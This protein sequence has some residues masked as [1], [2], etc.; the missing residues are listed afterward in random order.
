MCK[1]SKQEFN[2]QRINTIPKTW[3]SKTYQEFLEN[4]KTLGDSKYK[5]FQSKLI[6]THYEIIGLRIP[7]LRKIAKQISKTDIISFLNVSNNYYYEEIM[8]NGF[9]VSYIN[10]EPTFDEYF[11]KHIKYIDDWSLCDSFCNSLKQVTKNKDKYFNLAKELSLKEDEF[12]SR[13]GLIIILSHFIDEVYLK[14]IFSLLNTIKSEKYYINMAEA[15]L[16]CEI[17]TKFPQETTKYLIKNK[18]NKFTQNKSISK[19]RDSYRVSKEEKD[20]LNTLKRK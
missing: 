6:Y 11:L 2:Q 14:E 15:W 20:Y 5:D 12:I 13:V 1:V 8:L 19:I 10:E 18:L 17:Y 16:I 9:V 3:N 4:L 7:T